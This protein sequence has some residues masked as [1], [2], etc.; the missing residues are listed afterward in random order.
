M[1]KVHMYID[2]IHEEL[3]GAR[4]YAEKYIEYISEKP[5]WARMYSE[6]ASAELTHADYVRTMAQEF[7]NGLNWMPEECSEKW[8][9]TQKVYAD[10]T[11][12]VKMMLSR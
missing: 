4:H 7:I 2:Q 11:A 3:E 9:H 12:L 1:K 8:E 10:E 6:M 5:Q